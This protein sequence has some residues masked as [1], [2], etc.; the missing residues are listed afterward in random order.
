MIILIDVT[1]LVRIEYHGEPVLTTKQLAS[2][3]GCTT[4]HVRQNFSHRKEEF[5]KGVHYFYL[6]GAALKKFKADYGAFSGVDLIYIP[7]TPLASSLYLWTHRGFAR[8]CKLI[9]TTQAWNMFTRLEDTYFAV[10]ENE[11]P[12][13]PPLLEESIP[14]L[15]LPDNWLKQLFYQCE[16]AAQ[17]ERILDK[18]IIL[19][20]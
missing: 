4:R 10:L 2:L 3:Y 9:D 17:F 8:H 15:E 11:P 5:T 6:E 1:N 12:P 7:F 18:L 14:P 19:T 20:K 16:N 13:L